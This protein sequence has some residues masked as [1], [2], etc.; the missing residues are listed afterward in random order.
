MKSTRSYIPK[1]FQQRPVITIQAVVST[2]PSAK[3]IHALLEASC[4]YI[5]YG[6]FCLFACMSD[7]PKLLRS[8]AYI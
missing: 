6:V 7:T 5:A 4:R 2:I 8:K 1:H 3:R